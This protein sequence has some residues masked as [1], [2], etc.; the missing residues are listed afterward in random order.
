[1]HS[2]KCFSADRHRIHG[3]EKAFTALRGDPNSLCMA[4]CM[5][6]WNNS[7]GLAGSRRYGR[8]YFLHEVLCSNVDMNLALPKSKL[9][10]RMGI[11]EA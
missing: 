2:E 7:I 10:K 8:H 5:A 9:E 1:M 11:E 6:A 3:A 4:L